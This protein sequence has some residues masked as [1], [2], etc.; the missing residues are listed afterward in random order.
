MSAGWVIAAIFSAAIGGLALGAILAIRF[1][2]WREKVWLE[3]R[4]R[5]AAKRLQLYFGGRLILADMSRR[6]LSSLGLLKDKKFRQ[7]ILDTLKRAFRLE[8]TV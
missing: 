4:C 7:D 5:D 3:L 6:N 8:G 2:K 1:S